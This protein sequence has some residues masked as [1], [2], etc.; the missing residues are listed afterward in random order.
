MEEVAPNVLFPA[1]RYY[2]TSSDFSI[3]TIS[4]ILLN[5]MRRK[6]LFQQDKVF[7]L[8]PPIGAY[9]DIT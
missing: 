7:R 9:P 4:I 1:T 3:I 8:E 5:Y 6:E 2:T